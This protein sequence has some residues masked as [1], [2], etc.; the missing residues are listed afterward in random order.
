M[1]ATPIVSTK[2]I[3]LARTISIRRSTRSVITPAGRLKISHGMRWTTATSAI[4][5]GLR[6][7]ADAN[8]G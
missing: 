6:V 2:R 8:H 1:N 4:R 3:A 5:R 7:I